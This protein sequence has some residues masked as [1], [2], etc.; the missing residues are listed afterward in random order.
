MSI[1]GQII[2]TSCPKTKPSKAQDIKLFKE[3]YIFLNAKAKKTV[4]QLLKWNI[5]A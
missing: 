1:K 2:Q 5:T 3:K 4:F